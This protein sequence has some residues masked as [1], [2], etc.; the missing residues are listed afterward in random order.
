MRKRRKK[1]PASSCKPVYVISSEEMKEP[2]LR[3]KN[4]AMAA[5][6]RERT[7]ESSGQNLES[8]RRSVQA[9]NLEVAGGSQF[10]RNA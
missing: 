3:E 10:L 5:C 9:F 4:A 7:T 2:E 6:W 1:I 8:L